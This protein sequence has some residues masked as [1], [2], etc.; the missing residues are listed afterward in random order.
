MIIILRRNLTWKKLLP[1]DSNAESNEY[2]I[3]FKEYIHNLL[4]GRDNYVNNYVNYYVI[5]WLADLL[6]K[7]CHG[8]D[9]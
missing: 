9:C 5:A 8:M 3:I 2:A 4:N 7:V 6:C 1:S